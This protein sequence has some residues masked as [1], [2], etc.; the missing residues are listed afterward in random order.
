[1]LLA[2][3]RRPTRAHT[4][5]A[6]PAM[7]RTRPFLAVCALLVSGASSEPEGTATAGG[8]YG[9]GDSSTDVCQGG[10]ASCGGTPGDLPDLPAQL[11]RCASPH[12]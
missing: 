1:M 12:D 8:S 11:R 5:T 10:A 9:G 4:T 3:A 7:A 2:A 6:T